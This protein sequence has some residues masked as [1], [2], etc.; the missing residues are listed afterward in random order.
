MTLINYPFVCYIV[1]FLYINDIFKF[2]DYVYIAPQTPHVR[3]VLAVVFE[4]LVSRYNA[5]SI[6][7]GPTWEQAGASVL[8]KGGITSSQTRKY[9]S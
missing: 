1:S 9:V 5:H 7:L 4:R 6:A 2:N 3:R 8:P